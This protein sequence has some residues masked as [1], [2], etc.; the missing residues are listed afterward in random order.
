MFAH[1]GRYALALA[2]AIATGACSVPMWELL[3]DLPPNGGTIPN[4]PTCTKAL[5]KLEMAAGLASARI[6]TT[7]WYQRVDNIHDLDAVSTNIAFMYG[8]HPALRNEPV[9]VELS[10][11]I[12]M[13]VYQTHQKLVQLAINNEAANAAKRA[14]LSVRDETMQAF[15]QTEQRKVAIPLSDDVAAAVASQPRDLHASDF[16]SFVTTLHQ[17]LLEATAGPAPASFSQAFIFYYRAYFN[18]TYVDRFGGLPLPKP[19]SLQTVTDNEI[20]GTVQVL[21][22]F[23]MDY[24]VQTPMWYTGKAG[25]FSYYPGT[26][27]DPKTR[28]T[29]YAASL[30]P[31]LGGVNLPLNFMPLDDG[32]N[33]K[34]CGITKLKAQAIQ[35]IA[36]Q[37][38]NSAGTLGGSVGGSFGGINIGLGVTGKISVG[39]NKTIHSLIT[40]AL[41][42]TVKRAA[43]E[44]SY[45]VFDLIPDG[46]FKTIPDLVQA[47]LNVQLGGKPSGS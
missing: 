33:P 23:L 1:I 45:R 27:S 21:L 39:D 42:S 26:G 20:A 7:L 32:T 3:R 5:P 15:I 47:F 4:V 37:L 43:E 34:A 44:A 16:T 14:A 9:V 36:Q 24:Y 38:A 22:E 17:V 2:L 25:S 41:Q 30:Q 31:E 13:T 12:G 18:G 40:T 11:M 19:T 8:L 6:G 35:Y 29:V 28:P 10:R 46:E